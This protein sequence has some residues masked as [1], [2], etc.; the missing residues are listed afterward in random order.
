MTYA[1]PI[2]EFA[3][4]THLLKLQCLENKVLCTIGKFPKGI[5]VCEYH[6]AFQVPNIYDYIMKLCRQQAEIIQKHEN[7]NVHDIRK[8]ED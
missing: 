6:M 8:G 4:N 2:C 5:A 3:A 1:C 7:E